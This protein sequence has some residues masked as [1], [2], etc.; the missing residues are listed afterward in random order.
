[1]QW[2]QKWRININRQK[3]QVILFENKNKKSFK[4]E[5]TVNGSVI[6]EKKILGI[7][8]DEKLTFKHIL[9]TFVQNPE[10]TWL[11]CSNPHAISS[12]LCHNL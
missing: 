7:I 6:K 4:I 5:I 3:I 11:P 1:M 12:K 9:N 10:I 2:C 8:V